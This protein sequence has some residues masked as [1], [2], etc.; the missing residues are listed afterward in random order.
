MSDRCLITYC[1]RRKSDDAGD[2][3]AIA[4]YLSPRI[5]AARAK[6]EEL[7][8]DFFI[9][10]GRF[11]LLRPTDTIPNYD[12]LMV[13]ADVSAMVEKVAP[14][15]AYYSQVIFF[16]RTGA[17]GIGDDVAPYRDVVEQSVA[18][19][20]KCSLERVAIT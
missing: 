19:I 13:S 18:R 16:E 14:L 5:D 4:R 12:Y 11:G 15:L 9:L 3:P 7:G 8:A 1:C 2:I 6:A 20:A 10:S 17:P